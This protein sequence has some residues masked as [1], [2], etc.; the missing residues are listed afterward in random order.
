MSIAA[1]SSS[2]V[3]FSPSSQA[4]SRIQQFEQ[5]FQKLGQDLQSG[6]LSAAESAFSDLPKP[7][8]TASSQQINSPIEESFLQL[9][10]NLQSGN[11]SG[12]QQDYTQIKNDVQNRLAH[13]ADFPGS[14]PSPAQPEPVTPSLPSRGSDGFSVTA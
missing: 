2:A 10:Q 7:G 13:R 14:G 5:G 3:N 8:E 4:P 11:L 9:R 12:A 6:N 1:V